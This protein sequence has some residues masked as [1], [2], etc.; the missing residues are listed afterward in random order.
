MKMSDFR[1]IATQVIP[2]VTLAHEDDC[3][4][5]CVTFGGE[6]N[7]DCDLAFEE[8]LHPPRKE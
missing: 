8:I 4:T 1:R 6:C 7:F 2:P 3:V 5:D